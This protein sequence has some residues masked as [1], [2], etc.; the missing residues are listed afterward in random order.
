MVGFLLRR[1]IASLITLFVITV[2]LY[3]T[4]MLA[5]YWPTGGCSCQ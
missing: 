1:L 5:E 4:I 2:A 3:G